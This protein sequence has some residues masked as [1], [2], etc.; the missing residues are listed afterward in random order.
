MKTERLYYNDCFLRSFEARVLRAESAAGGVRAWLDRTAFYPTSGGQPYDTGTLGGAR[1]LDVFEDEGGGVVHLLDRAPDG[2]AVRGEI[3]WERRFDHMQQHTGQHLLSATFVA[4]FAFPT[5]SFHLGEEA[6]TIDL[7]TT[8][9]SAEQVRRAEARANEV[10]FEDRPV[11]IFFAGPEEAARLRMRKEVE[12]EGDLRLIEIADFDLT[13]C[14]GTHVART[15]QIGPVLLRKFEKSRQGWRVEF[16]CGGRA[17]RRARRD[18]EALAQAAAA[19]TCHP[20]EL[21]V[22]LP[23]KIEEMKAA[24]KERRRFEEALAVYEAREMCA[25]AAPTGNGVRTVEKVFEKDPVYVRFLAAQVAAQPSARAV[26]AVRE[27]PTLVLAQSKGLAADLG[28]I[29]K[30]LGLRG[31]GSRDSAQAGAQDWAA[32]ER[33]LHEV[34]KEL[35]G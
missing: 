8:S 15:G 1:V 26:F 9:L 35:A 31:G 28:A 23:G 19:L 4:T 11:R 20:H 6:S 22:R 13:A 25:Q 5:V 30:K 18:Y 10:V 32:L 3:D 12:R 7:A 17:V 33:A 34:R 16:V 24:E 27:P 21:P 2:E 14:G 29:I